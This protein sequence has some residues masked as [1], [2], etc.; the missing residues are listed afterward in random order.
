MRK[1]RSLTKNQKQDTYHIMF[2]Q[3]PADV[4][5]TGFLTYNYHAADKDNAQWLYLSALRKSKRIS[6]TDKSGSF[7][8]SDFSYS[9]M[10]SRELED[11]D[12]EVKK[13]MKADDDKV[14][15][16]QSTTRNDKVVEETGYTKFMAF[17]RQ[18]NYVVI[19]AI[20]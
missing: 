5:N 2:F 11:Y 4:N 12:F 16:I 7:M 18:G 8:G 17:V 6:S 3:E 1:I 14:W 20:H 15:V 10:T 13:E 19:R 9:D